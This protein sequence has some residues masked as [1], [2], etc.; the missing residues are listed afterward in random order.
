MNELILLLESGVPLLDA[1]A[2][3]TQSPKSSPE[4]CAMQ[5]DLE[6]GLT[7]PRACN[8]FFSWWCRNPFLNLQEPVNAVTFLKSCQ[9]VLSR[10]KARIQFMVSL[11]LYPIG[12]LMFS[13]LLL[14]ILKTAFQYATPLPFLAMAGLFF[15]AIGLGLGV[16]H[17]CISSGRTQPVDVLDACL[18]LFEQGYALGVVFEALCLTGAMEKK[19]RHVLVNSAESLS[20]IAAFSGQFTLPKSIQTSLLMHESSGRLS[21]GLRVAIPYLRTAINNQFKRK[22]HVIQV[23]LYAFIL[24]LIFMMVWLI[25]NPAIQQMDALL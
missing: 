14:A 7:L 4:L 3:L 16:I 20:F 9:H 21:D 2:A 24:C 25:Y 23:L 6:A 10:K 8:C 18:L 1:M 11:L 5:A 22:C 12:L 13:V 15:V 17:V 19:W